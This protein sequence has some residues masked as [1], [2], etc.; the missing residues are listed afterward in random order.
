MRRGFSASGS[1]AGRAGPACREAPDRCCVTVSTELYHTRNSLTPSGVL[2][3]K[4]KKSIANSPNRTHPMKKRSTFWSV[5][6]KNMKKQEFSYTILSRNRKN[7]R[8]RDV[9]SKVTLL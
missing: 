5:Q 6:D 8:H 7:H 4:K 2:P 9:M 3:V 1:A